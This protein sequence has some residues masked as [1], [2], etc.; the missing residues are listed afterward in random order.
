MIEFVE[1]VVVQSVGRG[2]QGRSQKD[3]LST[4]SGSVKSVENQVGQSL[5][6]ADGVVG[7]GA[8]E[9]VADGIEGQ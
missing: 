9:T 2:E 8:G 3:V 5:A 6:L 1:Q 4:R 7:D